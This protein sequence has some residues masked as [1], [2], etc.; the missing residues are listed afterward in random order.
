MSIISVLHFQ[1]KYHESYQTHSIY[2][3]EIHHDTTHSGDNLLINY[4]ISNH[5]NM[6]YIIWVLIHIPKL[7]NT[8]IIRQGPTFIRKIKP[9]T[10]LSY[11]D[12]SRGVMPSVEV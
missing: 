4:E 11:Q 12:S 7:L 8:F 10:L 3:F 6:K 2:S 5:S 1:I 9:I